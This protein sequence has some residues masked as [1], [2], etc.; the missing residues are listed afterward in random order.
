MKVD[1]ILITLDFSGLDNPQSPPSDT[2][3]KRTNL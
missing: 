3:Y 1:L 2:H